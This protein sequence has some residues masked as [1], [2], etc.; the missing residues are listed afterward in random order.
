[1]FDELQKAVK[2]H[3]QVDDIKQYLC[4]RFDDLKTD[5]QDADTTNDVMKVVH[6]DCT[7]AEYSYLEIIA[8]HFDLQ[9][10]KRSIEHYRSRLDD[11]CKRTLEEHS[12]AR[13][14][15][16]DHPEPIL[17]SSN[18]IEVTFKLKWNAKK[19]SLRDIR[20]VLRM[21]FRDLTD[22]VQIVVIK[23]IN[24]SVVVVC[25]AP[26]YLM[27]ELVEL[28]KGK[29]DLLKE[30]GVVEL[31][32]GHIEFVLITKKVKYFS[33]YTQIKFTVFQLQSSQ[34]A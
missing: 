7:L 19:K 20:D 13:S 23:D 8:D 31:T 32:V 21:V 26:Q 11:F 6:N 5:V 12:Y 14:F 24:G 1:M 25:W 27:T 2:L 30:V 10:A 34:T 15:R 18:K 9:E 29:L 33:V 3:V 28:A 17:P 16:V 22:R 4:D